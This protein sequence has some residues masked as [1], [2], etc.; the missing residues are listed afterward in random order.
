MDMF[1]R[2]YYKGHFKDI[3][4]SNH[5][6]LSIG[7]DV[8][9]GFSIPDS[10]LKKEHIKFVNKNGVWEVSCIGEV[11]M[12]GSKVTHGT[13]IPEQIFVLSRKDRISMMVISEYEQNGIEEKLPDE[14]T[15]GRGEKNNVVLDS[16]IV[17]G[18]HAKIKR[19]GTDYH[20]IDMGSTNGTYVNSEAIKECVLKNRD[21]IVIGEAKFIFGGDSL[22]IFGVNNNISVHKSAPKP[23]NIKQRPIYKR[24][25]RLKLEMPSDKIDI[26][27]PPSIGAKPNLNWISILTYP[28]IML[29][30]TI[31]SAIVT[32][33]SVVKGNGDG[34]FSIPITGI[35][36]LA[37]PLSGILSHRSQTKKYRKDE[38]LRIEKYKQYLAD[39]QKHI[40]DVHARQL[41]ALCSANPDTK[42]CAALVKEMSPKM[43]ERS[44]LD[45]DFM[46]VRIGNGKVPSVIEIKTP[47]ETLSL[48]EDELA[49]GGQK[50][51]DDNKY[52]ENAP[53]LCDIRNNCMVGVVGDRKNTVALAKNIV[54]QA[55]ATHSYEELRIVTVFPSKEYSEW[56]WIRWLP[57]SFDDGRTFR[58][59]A[60][61]SMEVS[62][63]CR[64]FEDIVKE[65][66]SEIEE[67]SYGRK[68][69]QLPYYLFIIADDE[70]I[71]KQGIMKTLRACEYQFGMGA[72][73]LTHS[74]NELYM[75][76]KEIIELRN[77]SGVIYNAENSGEF[78]E[79]NID[80]VDAKSFDI[81]ARAMAPIRVEEKA[82]A[83]A[84]PSCVT[85]LDGY[86]VK[87]PDQIPV[88]E[89][90]RKALPFKSMSVPVGIR[91]NGEKFMFDIY[92]KK[93][94]PFGLVAGM[95][96]SGK[97]EMVQSW[98]LSM[99]L[100]FSPS[101]VSFILIDFKG[102][103][104]IQPFEGFPH[105]AGTI[106]NLDNK[107]DRNLIALQCELTRRQIIF[108]K[109]GVQNVTEYQKLYHA[110]KADEALPFLII[111]IDEFA[112]FKLQFPEFGNFINSLFRT[113]RSLGMY[114][115]L[116][117]QKTTGVVTA[118]VEANVKFRWCLRV[119][120]ASDSKD[121]LHHGDAAKITVPGRAYIRI[122]DDEIYEQVQ[123]FWSG[124]PYNPN[125]KDK[126]TVVPKVSGITLQGKRISYKNRNKTMGID[127]GLKEEIKEI[128][129]VVDF[130]KRYVKENDIA[131]SK[132]VWTEKLPDI[133]VLNE[134]TDLKFNDT[135]WE[136]NDGE[137]NPVI[138]LIDDPRNQSQ[139]PATV[140]L[141]EL[142]H[143]GIYGAPGVGKTTLLQTL[144]MSICCTY[145]PEDV[146]VYIMDFNT[147]S[148]G[149]FAG[150]PHVGGVVND[151]DEEKMD[152]LVKLISKELDTR[153]EKFSKLSLGNIKA[154]RD[155]TGEKLPYI[156]L[157]I[158]NFAPMFTLYPETDMF[159]LNLTRQGASYGIYI[160]ATGNNPNALTYKI[161]QNI[162]NS[163][164]LQMIDKSEYQG[165]VGKT[166]GLEPDNVDGR[167]LIKADVPLE[168][169]TALP[170]PGETDSE[171]VA[172]IKNIAAEMNRIWTGNRAAPIPI[173]PDIIPFNSISA[174]KITVGLSTNEVYPLGIDFDETHY[175]VIS[176]HKSSGKSN[177]VSVIAKQMKS[178]YE[179]NTVV[180]YDAESALGDIK[181]TV[182]KYFTTGEE[183]DG[184]MAQTVSELQ[185][186]KEL[187]ESG[188]AHEA[189]AP[190][191]ILID[192][193]KKCYE[194]IDEKTAKRLEAVI[195]LGKG[196]NVY[197]VASEDA[198][199]LGELSSMGNTISML[200]V[201]NKLSVLLGKTFKSHTV[202]SGDLSY[203]EAEA[204]LGEFEGY[205]LKNEHAERFKAMFAK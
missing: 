167:G 59:M 166:N 205:I 96:G 98:I 183:L 76:C 169:Q 140:N 21:E 70:D 152:K 57:H 48:H 199:E 196:L 19:M 40:D 17:S 162:K 142:G 174:G 42:D 24:S 54:M 13:L 155:A 53:I 4:L 27:N 181:N 43:W 31:I 83:T 139:Y 151:S 68:T 186:R 86:N 124:A 132:K 178:N 192:G 194:V 164:A 112:E 51:A 172:A 125:K 97:S 78:E 131:E 198:E 154:Y 190:I 141:S 89:N 67:N 29:I 126:M 8:K 9:E 69:M 135:G 123:S 64:R 157:V 16:P 46:S 182:D 150:F 104:L 84:L 144:I 143:T 168:F 63:L 103:G 110:G 134:V 60:S 6:R 47:N 30:P 147:G 165:I 127:Y 35:F 193:L 20:L 45:D 153:K 7:S 102:T 2:I 85:F 75:E 138:G 145:S 120:S 81:F 65:R 52:V 171:R 185:R 100:A 12:N 159:F 128:N 203:S 170:A 201:N 202:F 158:D 87:T 108:N 122:G 58:F 33:M 22:E 32:Y 56:E 118:D 50:I 188:E 74:K 88:A 18:K 38:K 111:V 72:V 62:E 82:K 61:N 119:A 115:I 148:M 99:A 93:H 197:L 173:M 146:N 136:E 106:S 37:M 107:I 101:D 163:V 55:A 23:K 11:L 133:I 94:G 34:K 184:F 39:T 90:W 95:A 187:H 79:F 26:Q 44:P 71:K 200:L 113:G 179:G 160:A 156:V 80:K 195:R 10:D 114:S 92:E 191:A 105:L 177:M 25:P 14:L 49:K 77:G 175:M 1:I 41:R 28:L 5:Q 189:F 161:S 66:K 176:G 116:M 117:S 91:E 129:A 73:I 3:S 15:I 149:M 36:V 109:Y 121:M 137:L 204:K 130:L 180:L